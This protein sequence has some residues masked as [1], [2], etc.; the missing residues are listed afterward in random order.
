MY[1][2]IMNKYEKG[3]EGK[4]YIYYSGKFYMEDDSTTRTSRST[5]DIQEAEYWESVEHVLETS[6]IMKDWWWDYDI[7]Q[8]TNGELQLIPDKIWMP[9]YREMK[10]SNF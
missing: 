5:Y 4:F 2:C 6:E 1:L 3:I 7:F 10:P 8:L 9:I